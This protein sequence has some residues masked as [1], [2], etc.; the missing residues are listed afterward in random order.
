MQTQTQKCVK[1]KFK[2]SE[3]DQNP[4]IV[5]AVITDDNGYFISFKT[6]KKIYTVAKGMIVSIET[7]DRDFEGAI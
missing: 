6:A 1:I 2:T 4:N 5:Y 3:N 7:T